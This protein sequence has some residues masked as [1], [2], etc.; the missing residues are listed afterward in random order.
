MAN[1]TYRFGCKFLLKNGGLTQTFWIDDIKI[2]TNPINTANPFG[3]NRRVGTI[4]D[5]NLT[6]STASE[7]YSFYLRFDNID[8]NFLVDNI[9]IK[10]LVDEIIFERIVL[11]DIIRDVLASGI[12][13]LGASA[14]LS[15][16]SPNEWYDNW[17]IVGSYNP[18]WGEY[19]L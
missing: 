15:S 6:N 11:S 14:P 17:G 7:V 4:S 3:D 12:I 13:S 5:F 1:E 10:D 19:R 2:D 8:W 18:V 16:V 9:P